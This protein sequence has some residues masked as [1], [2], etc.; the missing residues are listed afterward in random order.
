MPLNKAR[1]LDDQTYIDIIAYL[2]QFN[3]IPAG[4]QILAPDIRTL[5][6]IVIEIP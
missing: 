1:S 3:G 6:Q 5:E 4:N 2:P